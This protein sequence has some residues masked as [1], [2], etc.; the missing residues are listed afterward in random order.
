METMAGVRTNADL[1]TIWA[2]VSEGGIGN[3]LIS[4]NDSI[5]GNDD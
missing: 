2:G 4:A 3:D 5:R 1:A